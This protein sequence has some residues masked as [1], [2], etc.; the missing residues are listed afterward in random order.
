MQILPVIQTCQIFKRKGTKEKT[1]WPFFRNTVKKV[2]VIMGSLIQTFESCNRCILADTIHWTHYNLRFNFA[3]RGGNNRNDA[4]QNDRA[5]VANQ[6]NCM[7]AT[8]LLRGWRVHWSG[9]STDVPQEA[10]GKALTKFHISLHSWLK[11]YWYELRKTKKNIDFR[12]KFQTE[13]RRPTRQVWYLEVCCYLQCELPE[14]LTNGNRIRD[15][16]GYRLTAIE[17]RGVDG[18]QSY[19]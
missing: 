17:S 4:V 19:G 8:Y 1:R 14:T 13:M 3:I 10:N 6:I 18:K 11:S 15:G 7:N 2:Y 9:E 16:L 12:C 5:K